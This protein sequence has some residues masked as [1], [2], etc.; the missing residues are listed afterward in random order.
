MEQQAIIKELFHRE[1][2]KMVTVISKLLGL[3]QMSVAED[4]VSETFLFAT[5]SWMQK[6][7]PKNPTA[8]LYLVAKQ[9]TWHYFKR[10]KFWN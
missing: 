2:S 4:I 3:D 8:W 7:L 6:G 9:K 5:E 1:F 10:N